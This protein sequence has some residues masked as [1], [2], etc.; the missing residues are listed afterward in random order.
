MSPMAIWSNESQERYVLAIAAERVEAFAGICARERCPHA[1]LGEATEAKALVV[2]DRLLG[3]RPVELPLDILFGSP[4]KLQIE[5]RRRAF[6]EVPFETRG[7]ALDAVVAR[8]L[9]L[10][11]V[12]AKQF[13]ITIGDRS[14]SGQVARDQLVGPW[15]MPVAD[16]A[17][18]LADYT[19]FRGEA[20]A[21]GERPPLALVDPLASARMALGEALTNI[22]AAN[23]GPIGRVKLSANWM[24]AAGHPGEDAALH[25]AVRALGMELAPA[26][27][28]AIP[29]GKDSLSMKTVWRDEA[30]ERAVTAPLSLV[31]TAFAP[32]V[33]ARRTLTPELRLDGGSTELLLIDLGA[34]RNRT[35]GSALA[36]V[37]GEVGDV[38]PD[39]DDPALLKGLFGA[40][41][42]LID[43][44][45]ALAWHDRSDGGLF[46]TLV[47]MA[48]A[49]NCGL[50]VQ[51]DSLPPDL[52]ATLFNEELGGVLQ[53]RSSAYAEVLAVFERHGLGDVV[54]PIGTPVEASSGSGPEKGTDPLPER[55]TT[56]PLV[57]LRR[58]SETVYEA[59]LVELKALWWSTTH[60]VQRLRDNPACADAEREQVLRTD[61]PGL[62]P[63]LTFDP[64]VSLIEGAA[65]LA[66]TRPKVAILREQGVNG[67]A[68]MAAAF[69]MAGFEAIDVHMSDLAAGSRV[70]E[71]CRGLAACGGFSYGDVL[72]AGGGWARSILYTER[73]LETFTRWF[74]RDDTFSLGV[75]N[76]CQMLSQ[77]AAIIPGADDW[78]R[79]ERNASE[80]F[81]ARLSTVAVYESPSILLSD[82]AGSR[83]P[84]AV[85]HGEG[86]AVF[87]DEGGPRR[88]KVAIGYVDNAGDMTERYPLNPNGSPH[89]VTGLCSE[90]GRVTILMP[91]PERIVRTVCHS[92]HP[93]EWGGRGPWL[94]LFENARVWV[95]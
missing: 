17:V 35:G 50:R 27:G 58:G 7:L 37:H 83:L 91:H 34:G 92:W 88:A 28:I 62:S 94:R 67:H 77:L 8:V 71:D 51:L 48:F 18:T 52:V 86:R 65:A 78:P 55:A 54:H 14:V 5:A 23:I 20:M 40:L 39:V 81:E 60:A 72:G 43:S 74:A 95:S 73:L 36:Q 42:S 38:A 89:G 63:R 19:G 21:M 85:A 10:P 70:L 12:A 3:D 61:D 57:E 68:E 90:D 56:G 47:E 22:V 79:F 75:C 29:V 93:P 44:G 16:V 53:V 87:A 26:L 45:H 64:A 66:T 25:D 24:A 76:G 4:P 59:S 13:L 2:T 80:Q 33:D 82:M 11:S 6:S 15:Q 46:V 69:D 32:V 84:V 49:A 9:Q 1:V 30:G 31:V 41:Q